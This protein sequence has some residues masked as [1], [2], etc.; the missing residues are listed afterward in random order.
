MYFLKNNEKIKK[1]IDH[2]YVKGSFLF[3][4]RF[5]QMSFYKSIIGN[6]KSSNIKY[7]L[8]NY[9]LC[10]KTCTKLF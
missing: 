2:E 3:S 4:K 6:F 8:S 1:L 10:Y 5:M 9:W 7:I